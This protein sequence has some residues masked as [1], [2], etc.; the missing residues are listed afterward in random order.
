MPRKRQEFCPYENAFVDA[1]DFKVLH[2]T[3]VHDVEPLHRSTDGVVV[4][5]D[6]DKLIVIEPAP[7]IQA[8]DAELD[9]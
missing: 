1:D 2:G 6:G 3:R 7:A 9:W 4:R 8:M 5:D